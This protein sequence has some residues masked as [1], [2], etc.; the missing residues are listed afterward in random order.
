[1]FFGV[2]YL[3]YQRIASPTIEVMPISVPKDLA[4][5]GYASEAVTLE[6]REALID[7]KKE[8]R[9]GKMT[10]SVGNQKDEP[11]ITVPETGISLDTIA[12]EIRARFAFGNSWRVSGSIESDGT[13]YKLNISVDNERE[14]RKLPIPENIDVAALCSSAAISIF[15]TID[16]YVVAA[17]L[18]D[19]DQSKSMELARQIVLLYPPDDI[20]VAWAHVLMSGLQRAMHNYSEAVKEADAAI[21]IEPYLPAAHNNRGAALYNLDETDA[22]I[23]EF[24]KASAIDPHHEMAH[25]NL[26]LALKK[27]GNIDAAINELH[28]AIAIDPRNA[29]AHN[30]L[31][32]ALGEQGDLDGA[33]DEYNRAVASDPRD[34][35]ARDNLGV[36]L[37][38]QGNLDAAIDEFNKAIAIDPHNAFAHNNLGAALKDKGKVG[39]AI[40][41]F[42]I[43]IAIDPRY[44]LALDNLGLALKSQ[45]K[46]DAAIN[47]FKKAIAI[48]PNNR[49]YRQAL[50]DALAY[51]TRQLNPIGQGADINSPTPRESR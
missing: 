1:V 51:K 24:N 38:R 36:A 49:S 6:L 33:I 27:K 8:A 12:A 9:T 47:Q 14:S 32:N 41:E 31:G 43:A 20:N 29:A 42:D 4:D 21:R 28:K 39:A 17:S 25:Y 26:G 44:A 16:P 48:E 40:D 22:A 45:G 5:K 19:K 7:L 15:E 34:L 18:A 11:T 3:L 37:I 46:L 23:D 35:L 30:S 10:A 2:L 13:L 50:A